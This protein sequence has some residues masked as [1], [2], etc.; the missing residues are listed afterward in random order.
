VTAP[1]KWF[2]QTPSSM[3]LYHQCP[4]KF[5]ASYLTKELP[6]VGSE[7]QEKG[8]R[9]HSAAEDYLLRQIPMPG[10]WA[11]LTPVMDVFKGWGNLQIERPVS[12]N[13]DWIGCGW[14]EK[15][16]GSKVDLMSIDRSSNYMRL[17]DFK[18]GNPRED[19]LQLD[20]GALIMFHR[21]PALERINAAYLYTKFPINDPRSLSKTKYTRENVPA[22]KQY[23]SA[24]I[25]RM[26]K[27]F[28][29]GDFQPIPT[30]LCGWC[31]HPTCH[32]RIDR[33]KE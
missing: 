8:K 4:R 21:M 11:Y 19:K 18:T 25:E 26:K 20:I 29:T 14:R 23:I 33:S 31:D 9:M 27:A 30:P 6:Y 7:A 15:E 3:G 13:K 5:E 1:W 24:R 12:V 10:E 22:L 32:H 2:G 16:L 17:V 28:E